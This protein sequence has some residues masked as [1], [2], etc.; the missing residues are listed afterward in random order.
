MREVDCDDGYSVVEVQ[1]GR[2]TTRGQ[3]RPWRLVSILARSVDRE[4]A[5]ATCVAYNL[6]RQSHRKAKILAPGV[7]NQFLQ[8]PLQP[9]QS[10][11][12]RIS[13]SSTNLRAPE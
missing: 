4:G 1:F 9:P 2:R 5:E 3:L 13:R 12:P 10:H 8:L 6:R 7:L 11:A